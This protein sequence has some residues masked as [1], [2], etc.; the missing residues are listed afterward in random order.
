MRPAGTNKSSEAERFVKGNPRPE[1][2]DEGGAGVRRDSKSQ[3]AGQNAAIQSMKTSKPTPIAAGTSAAHA[4]IHI[5]SWGTLRSPELTTLLQQRQQQGLQNSQRYLKKLTSLG[6]IRSVRLPG[7]RSGSAYWL[8]KKGELWL[9]D[10]GLAGYTSR[11]K[12]QASLQWEHHLLAQQALIALKLAG[13]LVREEN[14]AKSEAS[15]G[16]KHPDGLVSD[17]EGGFTYWLEVESK[18]KKGKEMRAMADAL[19][20]AATGQPV[21]VHRS[22]RDMPVCA[23][24]VAYD[25]GAMDARGY[26]LN[27]RQ[28]VSKAIATA[29][30]NSVSICFMRIERVGYTVKSWSMEEAFIEATR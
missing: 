9:S 23:A 10:N 3:N 4:L 13:Y 6:Y 14:D 2:S 18:T 16:I 17:E 11:R 24:L 28:R 29:T 27:H 8:T 15:F 30:R 21:S 5:A 26:Q 19:I 25:P 12:W 1:R 20:A 7:P 22:M